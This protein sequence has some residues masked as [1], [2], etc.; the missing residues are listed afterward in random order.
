M[1]LFFH[2]LCCLALLQFLLLGLS[3][4]SFILRTGKINRINWSHY[5]VLA[6]DHIKVEP[7]A[8]FSL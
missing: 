8:F 7:V 1:F 2:F 5:S 6:Y 3:V 4:F